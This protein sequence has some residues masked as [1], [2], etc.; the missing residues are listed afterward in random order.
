M[1]LEVDGLRCDVEGASVVVPREVGS[2][3]VRA[4]RMP[5]R[6][7]VG[8]R[9]LPAGVLQGDAGAEGTSGSSRGWRL[10]PSLDVPLISHRVELTTMNFRISL[11]LGGVA[12]ASRIY[13][14][15]HAPTRTYT[16]LHTPIHLRVRG[17]RSMAAAFP[18]PLYAPLALPCLS[19]SSASLALP[20]CLPSSWSPR[21]MSSQTPSPTPCRGRP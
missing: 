2:C 9:P 6:R 11:G 3:R 5:V 10:R 8:L 21:L 13:A 20:S 17:V 19:H 1:P 4:R 12:G 15:L 7:L 14:H 16:H 18:T